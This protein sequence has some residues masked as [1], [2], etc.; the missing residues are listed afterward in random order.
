MTDTSETPTGVA[1]LA[2]STERMDPDRVAH[3]V[4]MLERHPRIGAVLVNPDRE[5]IEA[6]ADQTIAVGG[7]VRPD[8]LRRM[9]SL[10]WYQQWGA[11]ADWLLRHAW[12]RDAD[13]TLTNVAGIHD[14]QIGEHVFAMLLALVRK[15]P[16]AARAQ[17]ERRW[18]SPPHEEF[19]ELAGGRM[20]V[21]GYGA[22]GRRIAKL[23]RAFDMKVDVVKRSVGEA[24]EGVER[25]GAQGDLHAFLHDAD[26]VVVALP[27][28]EDTS[29][30][31]GREAITRMKSSAFLVNIGR[32]GIVEEP[33]LAEAL[34]EGRLA[35]A[36]LDVFEDEPLPADSPLW[37]AP[38][39]LITGHYAGN[40]RDYDRR[41][42]EV[43]IENI[44][45]WVADEP[46]TR[47]VDKAAAY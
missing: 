22:I 15:L 2:R 46:L 28:T 18:F 9:P 41:A 31:I 16:Q 24:P 29:G 26:A 19:V 10:E 42:L 45:R 14:L 7:H 17:T 13:F 5:Q 37:S 4:R 12:A 35:G 3:A 39:A 34:R 27:L 32:G 21:L 33:A 36:G 23:A 38:N 1:I 43:F 20:L 40:T 47:V 25:V 44:E 6:V 8:L 11:G 30:L